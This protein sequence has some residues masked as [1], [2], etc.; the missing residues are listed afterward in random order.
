MKYF[1]GRE[2]KNGDMVVFEPSTGEPPVIGIVYG[3]GEPSEV[4]G[5]LGIAIPHG[6]ANPRDCVHVDDLSVN[7]SPLRKP[8]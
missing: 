6:R 4:P 5:S 8:R 7:G 3:V 1:N 2:A